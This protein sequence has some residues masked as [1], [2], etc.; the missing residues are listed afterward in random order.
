[1]SSRRGA[2]L[3]ARQARELCPSWMDLAGSAAVIFFVLAL[4]AHL[5]DLIAAQRLSAYDEQVNAAEKALAALRE[6]LART[7]AEGESAALPSFRAGQ[8]SPVIAAAGSLPPLVREASDGG[9]IV[10][11]TALFR[12]NS[13]EFAPGAR[14]LLAGIAQTFEQVLQPIGGCRP[15]VSMVVEGMDGAGATPVER[16]L[17]ATRAAV[18]LE[19][20]FELSPRLAGDGAVHLASGSSSLPL[21]ESTVPSHPGHRVELR[22][23]T[24]RGTEPNCESGHQQ[25]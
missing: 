21:S 23:F 8:T 4:V 15:S 11:Q 12:S 10:E 1:M 7:R 16:A 20:L 13:V 2:P 17:S 14:D 18:V 5:H 3:G 24:T 22:L 9:L 6:E 19:T 25:G